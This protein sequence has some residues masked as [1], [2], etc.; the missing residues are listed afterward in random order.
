[1]LAIGALQEFT[2]PTVLT[3]GGPGNS[4]T[5]MNLFIYNEAFQNL[6]FGM[7]AAASLDLST[8]STSPTQTRLKM[9]TKRQ[10]LHFCTHSTLWHRGFSGSAANLSG[11]AQKELVFP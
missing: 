2:L 5:L 9:L 10:A 7:V 1:M 6:H 4:T 3:G 8:G 11:S